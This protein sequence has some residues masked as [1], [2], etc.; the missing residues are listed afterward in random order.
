MIDH[1]QI[2]ENIKSDL[3]ETID[4]VKQIMSD[5]IKSIKP[6]VQ[7]ETKTVKDFKKALDAHGKEDDEEMIVTTKD[8]MDV[9]KSSD[10]NR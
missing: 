5:Q 7:E 2:F 9:D 3:I 10:F 8:N 6:Q 4:E 1:K